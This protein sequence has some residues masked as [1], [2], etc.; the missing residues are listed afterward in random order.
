MNNAPEFISDEQ[1]KEL[2]G[3]STSAP[4]PSPTPTSMPDIISDEDMA[5]LEG[6]T[7]YARA[8]AAQNAPQPST[9]AVEAFLRSGLQG[10]TFGFSDEAR[11][12]IQGLYGAATGEGDLDELYTK[13]RDMERERLATLSEEHPFA[14]FAGELAGAIAVPI[15]GAAAVKGVSAASKYP[16]LAKAAL[17]IGRGAATGAVY[18][19]GKSKDLESTPK[20]MLVGG[21]VGG[22]I[23]AAFEGLKGAASLGQNLM[24]KAPLLRSSGLSKTTE[25]L[26]E[27]LDG[28]LINPE[29]GGKST[30]QLLEVFR[31]KLN[32]LSNQ[33]DDA[34]QAGDNTAVKFLEKEKQGLLDAMKQFGVGDDVL[35][36][37]QVSPFKL[38]PE[39]LDAVGNMRNEAGKQLNQL[40][41]KIMSA[42]DNQLDLAAERL[43]K[44]KEAVQMQ[45][46][47][48]LAKTGPTFEPAQLVKEIDQNDVKKVMDVLNRQNKGGMMGAQEKTIFDQAM[49]DMGERAPEVAGAFKTAAEKVRQSNVI[50]GALDTAANVAGYGM[51]K[52][53]DSNIPQKVMASPLSELFDVYE[54]EDRDLQR[55]RANSNPVLSKVE[56]VNS[57]TPEQLDQ[58]LGKVAE[59]NPEQMNDVMKILEAQEKGD[60][61]K[62]NTILFSLLQKPS[63]RKH[64]PQD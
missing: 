51:K 59:S 42:K 24:T 50:E 57:Y 10:G 30:T 15:P 47:K 34:L 16:R 27:G 29:A 14:S 60:T 17:N 7:D 56:R 63:V 22:A 40:E 38:N 1:M 64:I 19:A 25:A 31:N 33:M 9:N 61:Q 46:Q 43:L 58:F 45:L 20:D 2:E 35:K 12:A 5:I 3:K 6:N 23:P 4:L 36:N 49:R 44:N 18:G 13:Y 48:D 11:G 54:K 52:A 21:A 62:K 37:I 41:Q 8:V 28:T 26:K 32:E 53:V 39:K 55:F